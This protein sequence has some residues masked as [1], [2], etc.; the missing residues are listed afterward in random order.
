MREK[1]KLFHKVD[2]QKERQKIKIAIWQ[3][4]WWWLIQTES[5]MENKPGR[6]SFDEGKDTGLILDYSSNATN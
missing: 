4:S 2:N 1:E 6:W 3:L 5:S